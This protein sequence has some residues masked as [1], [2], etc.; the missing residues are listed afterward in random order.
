MADEHAGRA[1]AAGA[2]RAA[3]HDLRHHARAVLHRLRVSSF[4]HSPTLSCFSGT[5]FGLF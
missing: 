5:D 1:V 4:L 2:A 3:D